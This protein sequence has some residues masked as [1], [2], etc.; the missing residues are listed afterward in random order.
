VRVLT[1]LVAAVSFWALT[2]ASRA[3]LIHP[4][5][6]RYVYV[7][8]F[9]VLLVAAELARGVRVG[10]WATA[11]VAAVAVAGVVANFSLVL[12]GGRYLGDQGRTYRAALGALELARPQ[13]GP[14]YRVRVT[15]AFVKL[16]GRDYF[17]AR[18]ALGSPAMS[19]PEIAASREFAR[20]AADRELI[21][22]YRLQALPAAAGNRSGTRPTVRFQSGGA[23]ARQRGCVVLRARRDRP[24]RAILVVPPGG[25]LLDLERGR[26]TVVLRR[27]AR[28]FPDPG[29]VLRP[30]RD[31]IRVRPGRPQLIAIPRDRAARP[32]HAQVRARA[33]NIAICGRMA[34]RA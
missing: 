26:A 3:L 32:W 30:T 4:N 21:G 22:A 20:K 19:P 9:F 2:G 12:D 16:G 17:A 31:A 8:A 27:F 11:A 7:G 33:G 6:S 25:L 13:V 10:R 24:A 18:D 28:G 5:A 29:P 23:L 14:R 1:L 15:G 34:P